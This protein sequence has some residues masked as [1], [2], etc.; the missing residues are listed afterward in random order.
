MIGQDLIQ[1]DIQPFSTSTKVGAALETMDDH[2]F[3]H[4]PVV[5]GEIYEGL[6]SESVLLESD[7]EMTID[8]LRHRFL[9]TAVKANRHLTDAIRKFGEERMSILPVIDENRHYLGYLLPEDILNAFGQS[10]SLQ[11]PGSILILEVEPHDYSMSQISQIVESNDAKILASYIDADA[12]NQMYR[13][14]IRINFTD[15]SSILA[16]FRRYNYTLVAAWHDNR[17]ERDLKERF[18]QFMNYLNM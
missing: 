3:I 13:V 11:S 5:E 18:D 6:I 16:T 4:W 17:Y 12:D 14:T 2:G 7:D 15:L 1:L 9:S 10:F 8:K